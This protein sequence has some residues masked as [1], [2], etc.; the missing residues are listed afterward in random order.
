L[1]LLLEDSARPEAENNQWPITS[2]CFGGGGSR[3]VSRRRH[4]II[5]TDD[6]RELLEISMNRAKMDSKW[7]NRPSG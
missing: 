2:K 4:I 3:S 1:L 6:Q 5:V 7:A